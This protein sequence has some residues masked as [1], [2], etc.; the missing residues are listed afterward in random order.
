MAHA[1]SYQLTNRILIYYTG[2]TNWHTGSVCEDA[3]VQE[4]N[5]GIPDI[6]VE[7]GSVTEIDLTDYVETTNPSCDIEFSCNWDLHSGE[8]NW[9]YINDSAVTT[10]TGDPVVMVDNK[11]RIELSEDY[12]VHGVGQ[13]YTVAVWPMVKG[14]WWNGLHLEFDITL[15]HACQSTILDNM[16]TTQLQYVIGS[17]VATEVG[18]LSAQDSVSLNK[19]KDGY[20]YCGRRIYEMKYPL[21]D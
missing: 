20:A 18:V 10:V 17:G 19:G 2:S 14:Y 3:Q 5:G 8:T 7:Y 21:S 9:C 12:S 16:S 1:L 15:T 11:W 13:T 4:K 6:R